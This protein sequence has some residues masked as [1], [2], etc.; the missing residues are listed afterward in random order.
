MVDCEI[1]F[2][3]Y[4]DEELKCFVTEGVDLHTI[5][6]T[7]ISEWYPSN[8]FLRSDRGE[9]LGGLYGNIWGGWLHVKALWVIKSDQRRGH[10]KR[11][12][13]AAESYAIEKGCVASSLETFSFQA[14]PFYER[15]GYEIVGQLD[16]YPL[17]H[18]KY[19]MRKQ[20]LTTSSPS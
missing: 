18:T 9:W 8:F 17:G 5:A 13:Q 15:L 12:L 4:P 20:L 11:L 10:G 16:D 2:E 14:R 7:G 19:F 6:V 1:L 3:P